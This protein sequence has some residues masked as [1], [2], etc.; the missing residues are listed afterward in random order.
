MKQNKI[1]SNQ[2][3]THKQAILINPP[4]IHEDKRFLSRI[5]DGRREKKTNT[6]TTNR[7]PFRSIVW[8]HAFCVYTLLIPAISI[9]PAP[10]A[11]PPVVPSSIPSRSA[12]ISCHL[13]RVRLSTLSP[14][15]HAIH[16][17]ALPSTNPARPV[18]PS[19]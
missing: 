14:L 12:I 13:S 11:T 5:F 6:P 2:R 4:T 15:S 1:N 10:L 16:R 9:I 3:G 7:N 17:T 8:Y 18:S 19:L